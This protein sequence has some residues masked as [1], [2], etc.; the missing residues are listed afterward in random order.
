M[1]T[2]RST[3]APLL[4]TAAAVCFF[5]AWKAMVKLRTSR[6]ALPL[7]GAGAGL[8][9]AGTLAQYGVPPVSK[10]LIGLVVGLAA[11]S[12]PRALPANA[13]P[14]RVSWIPGLAG[15]A[16]ALHAL[17]GLQAG[18]FAADRVFGG[19]VAAVLGAAALLLG[20]GLVLGKRETGRTSA[21]AA[22]VV[23]LA[24]WSAGFLGLA[25][26]NL[27]LLVV[28]TVGGTAGLALGR[29]MGAA[30]GRSFGDMLFSSG[31]SADGAGY[32]N[33]RTCGTEEA[34]MILETASNVV[35]IPGFGMAAAH[36]QHA[37][38]E[39]AELLERKGARVVW[40]IH[41]SAGCMP[42]HMNVV[43]DEANVPHEPV[44]A[45]DATREIIEAAEAVVVVGANDVV[46]PAARTDASSPLY[47]LE[48]PD[49][50]RARSV[51][52]VKRSLRPGAAGVKNPLFEQQNTTMIFG[53]AKRVAQ[54][55]VSELKGGG[56]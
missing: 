21:G 17:G 32:A 27:V 41:P 43:L 38:K 35:I 40:A 47:G 7:V 52:V 36:A 3:V 44:R 33:V 25:L 16:S 5:L 29:S 24:G 12:L 54:S 53:D 49:L 18:S 9:L 1:E 50:S 4:Y 15:G 28:G 48:S 31:P 39:M 56:H 19:V 34:A 42:G 46:N 26:G 10:I 23:L 30:A 20:V 22:L 2:L 37:V 13:A 6:R 8:A 11:L 51:F 14:A 45:L 55:L